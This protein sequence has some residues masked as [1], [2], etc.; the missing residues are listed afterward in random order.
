VQG[1]NEGEEKSKIADLRLW[2]L[3]FAGQVPKGSDDN[4]LLKLLT[5]FAAHSHFGKPRLSNT[6]FIVRHY[7]EHVE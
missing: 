6:S 5:N 1:G 4:W 3:S 2:L 7:A